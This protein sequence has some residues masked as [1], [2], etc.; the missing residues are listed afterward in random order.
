MTE[1]SIPEISVDEIMQKIK[2]EVERGKRHQHHQESPQNVSVA[3]N[4][5]TESTKPKPLKGN[6]GI[7]KFLWKYGTRYSKFINKVPVLKGIAERHYLRLASH[8][9]ST[10][11]ESISHHSN[12]KGMNFIGTNWYY[13]DFFEQTKKEGI[14]G[15]IKLFILKYF[16][17]FAWWQGQ[18]NRAVYQEITKLN[19]F[20]ENRTREVEG[21]VNQKVEGLLC[22]LRAVEVAKANKEAVDEIRQ[23]VTTKADKT[24]VARFMD[25]IRPEVA[26]KADKVEIEGL[27][28]EIKGIEALKA[29]KDVLDEIR[30]GVTTKAD[31][32]EVVKVEHELR[33]ILKQIRDHKRNIIDQQRRLTIFLEEARKRLPEPITT[34][35]IENMLKEKDHFLDAMYVSFEDQFRG[36]REDVKERQKVYLPY[37]SALKVGTKEVPI[38]DVGC[39][40]GEWLELLKENGYIAKGLDINR[41]MV[42]QCQ[43]LEL[44]VIE[45][46]VIEYL[47]KQKSNIFGAITGFHIVEHLPLYIL[48]K[49]FDE[50][51]RVLRPGGMVIFETPNPENLIVGACN[52]Y[53]D[54]THTNPI[55]PLTLQFLI[56]ARGFIDASILRLRPMP[57]SLDN[58]M[59]QNLLFGTTDYAVIGYKK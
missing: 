18:I 43:E 13:H 23:G 33:D 19:D 42:E 24:E 32:A 1:S 50:S 49:L 39:G 57:F 7:D 38:L 30:Q 48:I 6:T 4:P 46:D 56:E 17:F 14:K 51:F 44:D 36:T 31:K 53:A 2:E 52:F 11:S 59:L 28:D 8:P 54:P 25:E 29:D 58:E 34:G 55:P 26:T 16:G 41:M 10:R 3:W 12:E 20:I 40:R 9:I 37:I 47:R 5:S 27:R 21:T 22:E 15:K 35:Q 45:S